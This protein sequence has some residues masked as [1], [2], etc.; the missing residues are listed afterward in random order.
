M[1]RRLLGTNRMNRSCPGS[2]VQHSWVTPAGGA[3][4]DHRAEQR[5]VFPGFVV[6]RLEVVV[7]STVPLLIAV[8]ARA[9]CLRRNQPPYIPRRYYCTFAVTDVA[10]LM[11]TLHV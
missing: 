5:G 11:V 3:E 8:R 9:I 6:P 2:L 10:A 4:P 1:V 7:P